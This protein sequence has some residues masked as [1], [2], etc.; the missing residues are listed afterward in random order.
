VQRIQIYDIHCAQRS[1]LLLDFSFLSFWTFPFFPSGLFLS[2]F[3]D[4]QFKMSSAMTLKMTADPTLLLVDPFFLA[5]ESG[6]IQWGDL[7]MISNSTIKAVCKDDEYDDRTVEWWTD[8]YKTA[9]RLADFEVPD[10]TLRDY[11]EEHFPVVIQSL[12][13][14]EDGR[15]RFVIKFDERLNT[16]AETRAESNDEREEYAEWVQTRLIFALRQYSHK[17]RLESEGDDDHV[18][19]FAMAHPSAAARRTRAAIPTLRGFPVSWDRDLLD[20]TRHLIKL[21]NKRAADECVDLI[22]MAD[23]MEDALIECKDCTIEPAESGSPY[24]M[25]VKIPTAAEPAVA[26]TTAPTTAPTATAPTATAAPAAPT[27]AQSAAR[28]PM[29]GAGGPRHRPFIPVLQAKNLMWKQDDRDRSVHL[30][31]REARGYHKLSADEQNDIIRSLHAC[32]D[33]TVDLC[34]PSDRVF[35]CIVTK[36]H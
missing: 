3:L 35:F 11:I 6:K 13:A 7:E 21:H 23:N 12:P 24:L 14:S 33:C 5:M 2:F 25:V 15:E 27:H 9:E 19:I 31:K 32:T 1:Y 30:I 26:P 34:P 8:E 17:Y 28:I 4:F 16:W 29:G 10:L 18:A 36:L 22:T 20:H